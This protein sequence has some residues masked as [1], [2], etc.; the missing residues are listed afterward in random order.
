VIVMGL[1]GPARQPGAAVDWLLLAVACA[2]VAIMAR[3]SAFSS[4]AKKLGHCRS[5]HGPAEPVSC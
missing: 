2:L 1:A 5:S 3:D 4:A